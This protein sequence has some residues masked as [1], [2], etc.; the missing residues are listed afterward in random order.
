M[1]A[2]KIFTRAETWKKKAHCLS[3]NLRLRSLA[4][5][6]KFVKENSIVLWD[7]KAELPNLL[8]AILGR[9]ANG[10]EREEGKAAENCKLWRQ[11]LLCEPEFL[12]CRFF[13]KYSTAI[14]QDLWPFI[15]VFARLNR[16]KVEEGDLLSRDAKKILNYLKREG[17]TPKNQV[18]KALKYTSTR[19]T[20]LFQKAKMEL[21]SYLILAIRNESARTE[22]GPILDLWENSMPRTVKTAADKITEAEAGAKLLSAS[23]NSSVLTCEKQLPRWFTWAN[24]ESSDWAESLMATRTFMRIIRRG[25]NWIIPRKILR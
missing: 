14:H 20:R 8:D 24:G 7:A 21:H 3:V 13:R 17:P 1:N 6:R 19:D 2:E 9:I 10:K 12:E 16:E 25:D 18:R 23:L 22:E 5:A 4:E 15:T 11:Q